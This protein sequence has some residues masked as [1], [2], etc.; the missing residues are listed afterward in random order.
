MDQYDTKLPPKEEAQFQAWLK[1]LP[2][3]LQNTSDYDMRGAWKGGA[4][5]AGNGHFPDTYKKP[6]HPTF[7]DESIYAKGQNA[8]AGRWATTP[9]GKDVFIPGKVNLQHF[10]PEQLQEY[11][12]KV[13]P[14]SVLQMPPTQT[15]KFYGKPQ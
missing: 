14:N 10:T 11:F 5:E 6:N 8:S 1:T 12:K 7:S 13:E 3:R 9:D 15:E 2:P 4:A